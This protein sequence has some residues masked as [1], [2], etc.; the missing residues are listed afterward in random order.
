MSSPQR[1]HLKENNSQ[2]N[3]DYLSTDL[4]NKVKQLQESLEAQH[5]IANQAKLANINN[6][7][8][9]IENT[10][11]ENQPA[12][13][14]LQQQTPFEIMKHCGLVDELNMYDQYVGQQLD[15]S[16]ASSKTE[17]M[18]ISSSSPQANS[19]PASPN[20][21][22]GGQF[23]TNVNS[24]GGVH[25]HQLNSSHNSGASGRQSAC[26]NQPASQLHEQPSNHSQLPPTTSA[27]NVNI[28]LNNVVST[29]A[30]SLNNS[31]TS[32][33]MSGQQLANPNPVGGG[34]N[35]LSELSALMAAAAANNNQNSNRP[36]SANHQHPAAAN[37]QPASNPSVNNPLAGLNGLNLLNSLTNA[38]PIN[39]IASLLAGNAAS[40]TVNQQQQMFLQQATNLGK[41]SLLV[42][43]VCLLNATTCESQAVMSIDCLKLTDSPLRQSFPASI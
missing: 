8:N 6:I 31:N 22:A 24:S 43:F 14:M 3:L 16:S 7:E 26:S 42:L 38:S 29:A 9:N 17:E 30:N 12:E 23:V 5:Q 20:S 1:N 32:P 10:N 37:V 15:S 33:T 25:D 36:D 18:P 13:A 35:L 11:T 39:Q 27:V 19:Q 28:L 34:A 41:V 2:S 21:E 4:L 40:S